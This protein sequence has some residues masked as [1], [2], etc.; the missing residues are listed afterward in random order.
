MENLNDLEILD[1][2]KSLTNKETA[3]QIHSNFAPLLRTK[4][5]SFNGVIQRSGIDSISMTL[6]PAEFKEWVP[7]ITPGDGNCL[8]NSVSMS[9]VGDTTLASLLRMLTAAELFAH[10]VFYAKHPQLEHFAKAARYT[11]PSIVA[12]FLSHTTHSVET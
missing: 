6:L 7:L 3:Q 10:S 1:V 4:I 5:G 2:S 12:I 11:L 9:L 8:Y